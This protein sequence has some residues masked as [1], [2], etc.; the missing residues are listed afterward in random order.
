[1]RVKDYFTEH[2][3]SVGETYG[4]HFRVASHFAKEMLLASLACAVHAVLPNVF[5]TTAS[6]KVR[7]L[8]S[9]MTQE[10]RGEIQHE[11]G[12]SAVSDS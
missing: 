11:V 4:E 10:S 3:A 8:H 1:M 7:Q 9:E 6:S 12:T 2:P 5:T